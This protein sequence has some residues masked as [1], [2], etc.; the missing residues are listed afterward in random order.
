M[1]AALVELGF[2]SN[3][4]ELQKLVTP[5]YQEKLA[6]GIAEGIV[7]YLNQT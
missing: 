1:C 5:A 2:M 3:S 4:G 7:V 6:A